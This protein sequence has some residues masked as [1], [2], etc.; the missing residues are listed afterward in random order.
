M[1]DLADKSLSPDREPLDLAAMPDVDQLATLFAQNLLFD[2]VI[3][4][5]Q[6]GL[7][8]VFE[9]AAGSVRDLLSER[10]VQTERQYDSA[11][12]K[13]IY[14]MSLE[15]LIG[16][17]LANN[18]F[19]LMV[20]PV[21]EQAIRD[22]AL[23]WIDLIEQ[24]PDAG[25]GNG[26]LG[27]LA[28]C[29]LDSMAAMQLPAMGYGLRYEYGMF[30]QSIENGWQ[31]EQADNWLRNQDPWEVRRPQDI[32]EV[33]LGCSFVMNHGRLELIPNRPS[34]LVGVPY[35]RPV[36]GYG[37]KTINTLRLWSAT[38]H[39]DF[40]FR[41]FSSGDF[42]SA[43]IGKIAA[44]TVTRVLYPDDSTEMGQGLRFAQEYFLV[45]CSLADL[46]RRFR[47]GNSDWA[48]LP[49]KC[50]IQL[51]DT[52]PTLAVPELMRILLD[53]AGLGWDQ[54][55]DLTKRTLA[56]TNHTLLPEALEKWS[57]H[58]FQT[59]LP[60]QLEI[61]YEINHRFLDDVRARFPGDEA[62]VQR[63]SLI[64]EG[65]EDKVR[66]ANLAIVG[67]H[68]TN[69]VAAI[70]SELLRKLTVHDLAEIF[71]ER[72]SNKTNGVTHRRWL[73]LANP[74]LASA[75]S[76]VIGTGW[77]TDLTAI[78]GLRSVADDQHVQDL[79]LAA[80]SAAKQ[81]F[82]GWLLR[83]SG[84]SV[85]PETIFDCQVKRIHEYKRQMLNALRVIVLYNRLRANPDMAMVPRTFFFAGKAAP[86]YQRAK[87]I[88]KFIN[89]LAGTIDGDPAV[90]GR[91]KIVF[92]PEYCVSL[93]ERLIPAA[94]VS[95]QI[96][97]AGFEASGTSNMK[98]MM[99]G[100]LTLG[101]RD[102][103][104]IEM[105]Q[106]AGEENFFLFGLTVDEVE[107]SRGYYDPHWHYENEPEI[108]A[109]LD[110]IA[111]GH[112]SENE[113]GAFTP[114][115][116]SLLKE[117]DRYMHLADLSAYM[118]ADE[119]LCA[120][121][122]DRRAWARKAILNIAGSGQFSSDRTIAQYASEIW[123]VKPCPVA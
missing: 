84:Q 83:T 16:R 13:R 11:N 26:G 14:Y 61:I 58:H 30:K 50:A 33:K 97:T 119:A 81:D 4:P 9:A 51:N 94:D 63:V 66:M 6:A 52:H 12:P 64:E 108:R 110:L 106:E 3:D 71:P 45:A 24:E 40:D 75:I 28:A 120:N 89:N 88:I 10:W 48:L 100:A 38:S 29:F 56:Y 85:D 68:S 35:D 20:E 78:A 65:A 17:S 90:K 54:A 80:K 103:A 22:K 39:D 41:E 27:R 53:E 74:N 59:M 47:R 82:A 49:E 1:D 8:Q 99:N 19:N 92:L 62:K 112:F 115:L 21:L 95:N 96:S 98:F 15:F 77:L 117:G 2:S 114:L 43:L 87:L 34:S 44:H 7:R 25:L 5:S 60:R 102:G 93:A 69:G 23:N 91:L 57:L 37:N 121:Y 31:R 73:A 107:A 104:T 32:V 116:D 113:K 46:V 18:V 109:A 101:T 70:H 122:A 36:V 111:S 105:A 76:T 42:V 67:S 55:W 79:F 86:A 118:R 123:Q 72:F